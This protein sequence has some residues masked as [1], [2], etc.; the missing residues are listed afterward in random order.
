MQR[1]SGRQHVLFEEQESHVAGVGG[2][3]GEAGRVPATR[4]CSLQDLVKKQ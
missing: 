3:L 2:A 4:S 1:V